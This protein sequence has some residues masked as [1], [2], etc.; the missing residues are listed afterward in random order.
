[1]RKIIKF[2]CIKILTN[3]LFIYAFLGLILINIAVQ[4][5]SNK[6][7]KQN[8]IPLEAYKKVNSELQNLSE[9]EK[10]KLITKEYERNFAFGIINNIKN[11]SKSENEVMR[12]YSNSL[13]EE[14]IEIYNKYIN[15][16]ENAKF[17]YT[18][19]I[20]KEEEF[21]REIK[22]EFDE[23]NFSNKNIKDTAQNYKKMLNT[24]ISYQVSK[25]MTSFTKFGITDVV[26][27]LMLFVISSIVIFEEKEK[28]LFTIIK[29]I[30]NSAKEFIYSI[31][32][33]GYE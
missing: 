27:I 1:M 18:D 16:Y 8:E 3:K 26:I 30:L 14:N 13:K 7:L 11:L 17:E 23:D 15:E 10:E 9:N 28:N 5:Y 32:L 33:G 24:N 29:I 4:I 20:A 31:F 12:E 19:D 22:E 6:T 2:E 25:G 21:W